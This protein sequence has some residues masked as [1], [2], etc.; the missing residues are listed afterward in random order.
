M[1]VCYNTIQYNTIQYNTTQYHNTQ[2]YIKHSRQ[3]S[4]R[5]NTTTTKNQNVAFAVRGQLLTAWT[6]ARLP[7]AE[8]QKNKQGV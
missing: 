4:I 6:M 8:R 1:A 7:K 2:N 5:K 3:P